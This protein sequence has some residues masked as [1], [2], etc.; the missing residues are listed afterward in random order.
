M[1]YLEAVHQTR[2]AV[3]TTG[4][5]FMRS[6]Q[7]ARAEADLGLPERSLYFRGR[8]AVLG[9]PPAS[10]VANIF[11]IFPERLVTAMVEQSTPLISAAEAIEGFGRA[12]AVWG[13]DKLGGTKG[14]DEAAELLFR[15]VD[16][17]DLTALPLAAGWRA[18]DRPADPVAR[19]VH[20]LMLAREV[21]GGLHFAALRVAG[22]GVI[23]ATV[24]NPESGRTRL[25]KTGW[26]P[27]EADALIA[28]AESRTDL[29]QR[30]VRAED[31]T[32]EMFA[33][34]ITVLDRSETARLAGI[35]TTGPAPA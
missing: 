5:T 1:D 34:M 13:S 2:H 23:E 25:L 33:N 4:G 16:Q 32:D 26:R 18:Q 12:C 19:L 11:G 6:R 7:M 30:W 27:E 14:A 3:V 35:L 24:A 31:L 10:I 15:I 9:D 28:E 17:A 29:H 20:A 8:S 22:L 21:R